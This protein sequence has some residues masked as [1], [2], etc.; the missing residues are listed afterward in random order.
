MFG[1][2]GPKLVIAEG[3]ETALS[4]Y[5]AT[6]LPTWAALSTSGMLNVKVPPLEITQKII[7]AADGDKAGEN[8]A[9]KT[10]DKL[11]NESYQVSIALAPQ[12]KDFNDLLMRKE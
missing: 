11:I 8:A 12:A 10:A 4:V 7:I 5:V 2:V 1:T 6:G 9:Y 3:I